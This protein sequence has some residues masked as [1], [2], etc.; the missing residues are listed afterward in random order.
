MRVYELAKQLGME[1]RE[2]IPELKRLGIPVASHSSAL[3]EDSVRIVLEKV[4]SKGRLG[5]TASGG[6]DVKRGPRTSKESGVS[7]ERAHAVMHDEPQKPDKKRI[8]IKKKHEE[9]AEDTIAPLAAAEASFA[10]APSPSSLVVEA[11]TIAP[12]VGHGEEGIATVP[13]EPASSA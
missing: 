3:D 12:A 1:N 4:G 7:H 13:S 10:A 11:A 2:L 8:L 9:G 6:H 5:E